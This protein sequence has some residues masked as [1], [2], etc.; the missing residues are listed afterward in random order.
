MTE[1]RLSISAPLHIELAI[2]SICQLRCSYCSAMPFA[3]NVAPREITLRLL[4][5]ICEAKV[6]SLLISGGEPTLHP[7]FFDFLHKI[8]GRISEITVNTNGI[9][10]SHP[11]YAKEFHEISPKAIVAVSLD[12]ADVSINNINRGA[13]GLQAIKAIDNLCNFQHPICISTVLT[14]NNIR[15]AEHLIDRFFPAV[16]VFRFF[17]QVPRNQIEIK[18][19]DEDYHKSVNLFFEKIQKRSKVLPELR[20]ILP[21]KSV[22][23]GECGSMLK[24]LEYCCC[25]FTK[26]FI[27]SELNAYPCYYS[28]NLDTCFGNLKSETLAGIWNSDNAKNIRKVATS[29]SLCNLSSSRKS[30]PHKYATIS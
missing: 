18:R 24:E 15:S 1:N 7:N 29:N 8:S 28:S 16:K 26:L 14:P 2:T 11:S 10:L 30:L 13:G 5:E 19:N 12:S 17:P 9:K 6:F 21:Y 22:N 25:P 3:G 27:D 23:L 4:E 20:A